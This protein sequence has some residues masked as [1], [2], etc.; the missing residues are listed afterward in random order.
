MSLIENER[1]KLLANALDRAS[2][3]CLTVGLLAPVAAVFYGA[4]GTAL[5]TWTFALGGG[6]W[7]FAAVALHLVARRVLGGLRS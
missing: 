1:T 5:E 2:T 4:G 6:I 3:A 7:L